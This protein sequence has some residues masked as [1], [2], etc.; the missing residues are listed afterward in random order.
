MTTPMSTNSTKRELWIFTDW[1]ETITAHDTLAFIAPPDST[2]EN[3]PPPWSYFGKYYMDLMT[4]HEKAFGPR[5]TLERQLAYLE[6][7]TPVE[8]A[9]VK[10]VEEK[11]LFKGVL[12]EDIQRRAQQVEF[13]DGWKDF[14]EEVRRKEHVRL[15]GILSVNWSKVFIEAALRRI[16]DDAFMNEFEIRANVP[17]R[18]P[19][20]LMVECCD[21]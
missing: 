11:G 6:S 21:G 14:T 12:E 17:P 19:A 10:E 20:F 9:S 8:A 18:Q 7:L 3:A 4:A 1:D 2:K 16:H 5:T 15:M 13:R